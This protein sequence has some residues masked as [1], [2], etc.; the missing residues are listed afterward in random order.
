MY[1]LIADVLATEEQRPALMQL[2]GEA[3]CNAPDHDGRCRVAWTLDYESE[4]WAGQ[5]GASLTADTVAEVRRELSPIPVLPEAEVD[6]SLGI[7]R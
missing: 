6:R 1:R 2:I 4:E 3:L 5:P 7:P